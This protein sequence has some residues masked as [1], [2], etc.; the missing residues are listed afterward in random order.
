MDPNEKLHPQHADDSATSAAGTGRDEVH[1]GNIP[2]KGSEAKADE[3]AKEAYG[4][5]DADGE[6]DTPNVPFPG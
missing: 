3:L 1:E 2:V 6:G 5:K 4:D